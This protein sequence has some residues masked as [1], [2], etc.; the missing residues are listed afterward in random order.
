M[1]SCAL[2][3]CRRHLA[4]P[5]L[6]RLGSS[7]R[8]DTEN[9]NLQN[10]NLP[11]LTTFPARDQQSLCLFLTCHQSLC[12]YLT[13]HQQR[14]ATAWQTRVMYVCIHDALCMCVFVIHV[15]SHACMHAAKHARTQA[16]TAKAGT[17]SGAAGL[18]QACHLA[19]VSSWSCLAQV[20][21]VAH[22]AT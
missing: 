13:R 14:H 7:G 12:L 19:C 9:M 1:A 10:M 21:Q 2:A 5:R 16:S 18:Q 8:H 6:W 4:R 15:S 3:A 11:A 20:A 22:P 17:R